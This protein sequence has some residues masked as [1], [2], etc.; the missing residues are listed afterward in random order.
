MRSEIA[1]PR[2]VVAG[3][4]SGVGKTT[5]TVGLVRALRSRGLKVAVFKCGPD[6]LDPTY[7]ARA[8][9][10]TSHNLDG[11]MM[12]GEAVVSTFVR[13]S[14]G[15]DIAIIEGV[16]GLFDGA[17]ATEQSGST[18]EIAKWLD[19]PVLLVVDASG[20]ARSVAA[21]GRGFAEFD[22]ELRLAALI[23]NRVGSKGH[24]EILKEASAHPPVIGG[25]PKEASAA[26]P[27]R[28]LGLRTAEELAGVDA[29]FSRWG[30]L[31]NEWCEVDK[32]I[33][34]AAKAPPLPGAIPMT[35]TARR[36]SRCTIGIA[37]DEA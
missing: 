5:F 35:A 21:V 24:L 1:I 11:W 4:S 22:R 16:M 19:A 29:L 34:I 17:S 3:T 25:L 9:G 26:F 31:V 12:G 37:Y 30:A 32:I 8:A 36:T 20:M 33:S 2:L 14:E 7:H 18:A 15:A 6:Y 10:A 13:A 28:H 23:C 27:E